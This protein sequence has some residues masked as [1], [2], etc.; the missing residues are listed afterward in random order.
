MAAP[1]PCPFPG[2]VGPVWVGLDPLGPMGSHVLLGG[3]PCSGRTLGLTDFCEGPTGGPAVV[4][5]Q[6][7]RKQRALEEVVPLPGITG[8]GSQD[9][10]GELQ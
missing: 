3:W 5:L 10:A 6:T 8:V 1:L 7:C 9:W 4:N 2:D